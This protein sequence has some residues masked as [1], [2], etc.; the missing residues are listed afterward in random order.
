MEILTAELRLA[1]GLMGASG[2]HELDRSWL[3]PASLSRDLPWSMLPA[4]P[5]P[6]PG[7]ARQDWPAPRA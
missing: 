6:Q 4:A 2:V 1:M 3:A 5:V 7:G